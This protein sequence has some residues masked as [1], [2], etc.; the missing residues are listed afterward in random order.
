MYLINDSG[1]QK[2][3]KLANKTILP[4]GRSRDLDVF[5]SAYDGIR[6][7]TKGFK[8]RLSDNDLRV[9][10]SI[11]RDWVEG[12][13]LDEPGTACRADSRGGFDKLVDRI[14]SRRIERQ[15]AI[16]KAIR[17]ERE[18]EARIQAESNFIDESGN[19][20]NDKV[21]T[22]AVREDVKPVVHEDMKDDLRSVLENNLAIMTTASGK[23]ISNKPGV[24]AGSTVVPTDPKWY[25]SH[26]DDVPP[27]MPDFGKGIVEGER[28][29]AAMKGAPGVPK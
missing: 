3:S 1:S 13:L 20:V 15:S 7:D 23:P 2:Y 24:V 19:P 9:L 18:K 10:R 27:G 12:E 14:V 22:Q 16:S 17:A 4:G 25:Q 5:V 29:K 28:M 8:V 21:V 11:V 26:K 6:K